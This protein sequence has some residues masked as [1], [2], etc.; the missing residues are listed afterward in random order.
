MHV[1]A[2]CSALK[3]AAAA[4]RNF[5]KKEKNLVWK[6]GFHL[7]KEACVK[8]QSFKQAAGRASPP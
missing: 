2:S 1:D 6:E 3:L 7:K 5:S 8:F 4:D